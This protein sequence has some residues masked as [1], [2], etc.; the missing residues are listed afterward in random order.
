[1]KCNNCKS[2]IWE[3]LI[4]LK[5]KESRAVCS[6]SLPTGIPM[7]DFIDMGLE[8]SVPYKEKIVYKKVPV[9]CCKKCGNIQKYVKK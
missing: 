4:L 9:Y 5:R 1:M 8:K 7:K 6:N 3:R 2:N